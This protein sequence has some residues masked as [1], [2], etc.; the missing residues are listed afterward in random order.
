MVLER[1]RALSFLAF[2]ICLLAVIP[3]VLGQNV[4]YTTYD[5]I[6]ACSGTIMQLA[7]VKQENE[8]LVFDGYLIE[9][10]EELFVSSIFD[11]DEQLVTLYPQSGCRGTPVTKTFAEACL[12]Y[13]WAY[14][15]GNI[16]CINVK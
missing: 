9:N 5:S 7:V 12:L 8:C 15:I 13:A 1:M 16:H 6:E 2:F 4:R 10:P 3:P 11:C 14:T